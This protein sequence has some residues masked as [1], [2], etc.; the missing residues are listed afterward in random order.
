MLPFDRGWR[1]RT[2]LRW[3]KYRLKIRN[4][5]HLAVMFSLPS[6]K[7]PILRMT[8]YPMV[9][10]SVNLP[11][12]RMI[13]SN[14]SPPSVN[15]PV[16]RMTSLNRSLPSVN[17]SILRMIIMKANVPSVKLTFSRTGHVILYV[18]SG[19]LRPPAICRPCRCGGG[20]SPRWLG[21]PVRCSRLRRG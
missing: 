18:R 15:P 21:M 11:I 2:V 20:G 14:L 16:L 17:R 6:V 1:T 10:L 8:C 7:M 5:N 19:R 3:N 12:L 4:S 13:S 9:L